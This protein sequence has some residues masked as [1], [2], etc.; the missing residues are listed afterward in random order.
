MEDITW[1]N[2]DDLWFDIEENELHAFYKSTS[3]SDYYFHAYNHYSEGVCVVICSK[4]YFKKHGYVFDQSIN[5]DHL[6][7]DHFFEIMESE[8][9]SDNDL[10]TTI[11]EMEEL[12]FTRNE[13]FS[14]LIERTSK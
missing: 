2:I 8:W 10:N 3:A 13:A 5:I 12:G 4:D 11:K 6:L 7:P 14:E 9:V 1:N